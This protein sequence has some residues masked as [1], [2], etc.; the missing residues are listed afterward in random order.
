MRL[1][2]AAAITVVA[3]IY[4]EVLVE[5]DFNDGTADGW[6]EMPTGAT[7]EVVDGRYH[8]YQASTD[9]V[10]AGS[11]T[12][13]LYGSMSVADYSIRAEV[14]IDAGLLGGVV[15]RFDMFTA[16]GYMLSLLT[17]G[18]GVIAI[19]RIDQGEAIAIAY[20][21]TEIAYGQ[22]YWVRFEAADSLLGAKVWTGEAA[23]E[24]ET[25]NLTVVDE[26]YGEPGSAGLFGLDIPGARAVEMDV[27]FDDFLVEDVLTLDLP[28]S[29]WGGIKAGPH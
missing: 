14:E 15:S 26:T 17:D 2:I 21:L 19:N 28:A 11:V 24:P 16:S 9:S 13:D 27:W 6:L 8:F 18:G 4:A 20:T 12:G 10:Y 22:K 5:D 3:L 1:A 25:W 29:T 7:Y 23:D